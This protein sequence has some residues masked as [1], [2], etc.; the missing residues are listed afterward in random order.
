MG[1]GRVQV[2]RV[3]QTFLPSAVCYCLLYI[4]IYISIYL[5]R[6]VVAVALEKTNM[7]PICFSISYGRTGIVSGD[8]NKIMHRAK[9]HLF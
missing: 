5:Y 2:A 9:G 3:T 6:T 8:E 4:Y 7:Q 1:V